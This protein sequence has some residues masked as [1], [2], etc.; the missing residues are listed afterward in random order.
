VRPKRAWPARL[1]WPLV[2]SALL[3]ALVAHWHR[4]GQ[5]IEGG[6]N[7]FGFDPLNELAKGFFV[8]NHFGNYLGGGWS[9]G[10]W[11]T[12]LLVAALLTHTLGSEWAQLTMVAATLVGGWLGLYFLARELRVTRSAAAIGAWAYTINPW[13]QMFSGLN[14]P[15]NC[16][17]S[18]LPWYAMFL[19]R[20]RAPKRARGSYLAIAALS[21]LLLCTVG[22][23]A[24]LV[25]V[26]FAG[27]GIATLLGAVSTNDL[28]GYARRVATA[29][30]I[31]LAAASWWLF[32]IARHFIGARI[33][34]ATDPSGWSFVIERSSLLNNLR[35]NAIWGWD[36]PEYFP[37]AKSYDL[38]P[39]TYA[40]GYLLYAAL[41]YGLATARGRRLR[42]TRLLGGVTIVTIFLSK[43]LHPPLEFVNAFFYRLPLAAL[44]REPTGKFP[45]L[46][47]LVLALALAYAV[48][49]LVAR[50]RLRKKT[51]LVPLLFAAPLAATAFSALYFVTGQQFHGYTLNY[52]ANAVGLPP[53]YVSLPEYWQRLRTEMQRRSPADGILV[54]PA[55]S[56]YQVDYDWG[57]DGADYL[58]NWLL[59]QHVLM[60][61]LT[62]YTSEDRLQSVSARL[63]AGF[64]DR[65]ILTG[66]MLRDLGIRYVL[67]RGD[68][69]A[70][71]DPFTAI[72]P[73]DVMQTLPTATRTSFGP[74]TLFD[75]RT[76]ESAVRGSRDVIAAASQETTAGDAIETRAMTD[77]VP[78][79]SRAPDLASFQ[80]PARVFEP[81]LA[82]VETNDWSNIAKLSVVGAAV[83]LVAHHTVPYRAQLIYQQDNTVTAHASYLSEPSTPERETLVATAAS[84]LTKLPL[85]LTPQHVY[86]DDSGIITIELFDPVNATLAVAL[87]ISI[88]PGGPVSGVLASPDGN[89]AQS[90]ATSNAPR[91][92]HFAAVTLKPGSNSFRLSVVALNSVDLPQPEAALRIGQLRLYAPERIT[93]L[94]TRLCP[95]VP[96]Q[97]GVRTIASFPINTALSHTPMLSL[98]SREQLG[99]TNAAV[100]VQDGPDRFL[101]QIGLSGTR[102]DLREALQSCVEYQGD[103]RFR[104]TRDPIVRDVV[105]LADAR[106]ST[107]VDSERSTPK[108]TLLS[109]APQLAWSQLVL[110]TADADDYTVALTDR[111]GDR[112]GFTL[113]P[114]RQANDEYRSLVVLRGASGSPSTSIAGRIVQKRDGI[115]IIRRIDGTTTEVPYTSVE[116]IVSDPPMHPALSL[117]WI[118]GPEIAREHYVRISIENKNI[119]SGTIEVRDANG[120]V[121]STL[122]EP[123]GE[124]GISSSYIVLADSSGDAFEVRSAKLSLHFASAT[125]DFVF[126]LSIAGDDAAR[127]T[128]VESLA[129]GNVVRLDPAHPSSRLTSD[130]GDK[131]ATLV[132]LT[133]LDT[134]VSTLVI[135]REHCACNPESTVALG[136]SGEGYALA[137]VAG[138]GRQ[139]ITLQDAFSPDWIGLRWLSPG[140]LPH[141]L[142]DNW[143]NGWVVDRPGTI[144]LVNLSNVAQVLLIFVGFAVVLI[145]WRRHATRI[146]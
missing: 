83:R 142:V 109:D 67:Y 7:F 97:C 112:Y 46:T 64:H 31:T 74:L 122:L 138:V 11:A 111:S 23:N 68:V 69:S 132:G 4:P 114:K 20:L 53:V 41:C 26:F 10:T 82:A 14:Y 71:R 44:F 86:A 47:M 27:C 42:I 100:V 130:N 1:A 34:T 119:E 22:A 88:A 116:Q 56:Y 2:S 35:L 59:P 128:R 94:D 79:L 40:S 123:S 143:R 77:T 136:V 58:P 51:R 103:R 50:L 87:D 113:H 90:V 131:R 95:L 121:K 146:R 32:L 117:Q 99:A 15:L 21:L 127:T 48:D 145:C 115:V 73:D 105:L 52:H 6:D 17:I 89:V 126:Q 62:G 137:N 129:N 9:S 80:T 96:A 5:L 144:L 65:S 141:V 55:D 12:W 101:C 118:F 76:A 92:I 107:L 135:G 70:A 36:H 28:T 3:V 120:H 33:A 24:G 8:W 54:L 25:V 37:Y 49:A 43:G 139:I 140:V 18:L 78:R 91:F 45:I 75:A 39:L 57:Y 84:D 110:P 63:L 98:T 124:N 102:I 38:N 104:K 106:F 30:G 72:T 81:A 85:A 16:L 29:F 61:G 93:S 66:T 125:G 133:S 108:A 60:P 19:L 13:Q 134:R